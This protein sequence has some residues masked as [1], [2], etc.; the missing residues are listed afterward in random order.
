MGGCY[1][2]QAK[3]R[4]ILDLAA[5]R[6]VAC[7]ACH[8]PSTQNNERP[9]YAL[10]GTRVPH[11]HGVTRRHVGQW[12]PLSPCSLMRDGW[13]RSVYQSTL[14]SVVPGNERSSLCNQSGDLLHDDTSAPPP[15]HLTPPLPHPPHRTTPHTPMLS[16]AR[17]VQPRILP[18]TH[19]FCFDDRSLPRYGRATATVAVCRSPGRIA[20]QSCNRSHDHSRDPRR[21]RQPSVYQQPSSGR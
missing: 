5:R 6:G 7:L 1:L 3:R 10:R 13:M 12:L 16:S 20:D 4:H 21:Y 8:H 18:P 11:S 9:L 15:P 19:A 17:R 14:H 2:L